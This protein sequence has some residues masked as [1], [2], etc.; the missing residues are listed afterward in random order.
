MGRTKVLRQAMGRKTET[1][2]ECFI[3]PLF[4]QALT[5]SLYFTLYFS[6][7]VA[8]VA[9]T[10]HAIRDRHP[11]GETWIRT[12]TPPGLKAKHHGME[13]ETCYQITAAGAHV[14]RDCAVN[15]FTLRNWKRAL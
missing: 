7:N 5:C 8:D 4:T 2:N 1:S 6:P 12:R 9:G 14:K 10:I 3:C 15:E 13:V 11:V